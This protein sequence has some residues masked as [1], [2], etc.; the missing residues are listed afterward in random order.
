M[1]DHNRRYKKIVRVDDATDAKIRAYA[2]EHSISASEAA[3]ALVGRADPAPAVQ[4]T[5]EPESAAGQVA[6]VPISLHWTPSD[7]YKRA[8]LG[9]LNAHHGWSGDPKETPP[10][11]LTT[12]TWRAM[13]GQS[14][15]VV[16]V[17]HEDG[18]YRFVLPG[19]KSAAPSLALPAD[20]E[21]RLVKLAARRKKTLDELKVYA[22]EVAAG[23][24]EAVDRFAD[25][26]K[27][28]AS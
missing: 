1:S 23:R 4:V 12:A 22:L 3:I 13:M 6:R 15:A 8:L 26:K 19:A 10:E 9:P 14:M 5:H 21:G 7:G 18:S 20:L 17:L 28:G 25:S 2:A 16:A 27:G 24:L 11:A